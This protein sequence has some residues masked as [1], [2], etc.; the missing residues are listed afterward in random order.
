MFAKQ[1]AGEK[2]AQGMSQAVARG[3]RSI[4]KS[5]VIVSK[6]MK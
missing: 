4:G 2:N 6:K 5:I 1:T 3:S